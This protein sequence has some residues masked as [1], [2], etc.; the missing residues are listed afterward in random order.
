M[1]NETP[2]NPLE[3][4]TAA[5]LARLMKL[6]ADIQFDKLTVSFSI[7]DRDGNGRKKSAFYSVTASRGTGAEIPQMHENAQPTGFNPED[8]K[9]VRTLLCKHVVRAVYEDA[10]KR[11]V[12]TSRDAAQEA[13]AV[14]AS[15]DEGLVK[16]LQADDAPKKLNGVSNGTVA[17]GV[18]AS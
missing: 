1:A 17:V 14:L 10:A 6:S 2:K 4:L 5:Q 3:S 9:I 8:V 18:G 11:Q 12:M 16:L 7:E 15:Y 13:R